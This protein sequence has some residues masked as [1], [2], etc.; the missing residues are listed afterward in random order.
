M[1]DKTCFLTV[2]CRV[3]VEREE[4]RQME[5]GRC[6]RAWLVAGRSRWAQGGVVWLVAVGGKR[7]TIARLR[8]VRLARLLLG[9]VVTDVCAVYAVPEAN[10]D[11]PDREIAQLYCRARRYGAALIA[12]VGNETAYRSWSP[13]KVGDEPSRAERD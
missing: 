7:D 6:G 13:E 5:F 1:T 3:T 10:E 12:F 8:A 4:T 11:E 2:P 9:G